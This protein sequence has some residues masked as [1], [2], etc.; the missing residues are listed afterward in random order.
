[1]K[2]IKAVS[3][4]IFFQDKIR[5]LTKEIEDLEK[6]LDCRKEKADPDDDMDSNDE[7]EDV[8]VVHNISSS[9]NEDQESID[10]ANRSI[11]SQNFLN[12]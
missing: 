8:D 1:M 5:H 7:L 3:S 4:L 11:D 12:L 9:D 2:R 10:P 6:K